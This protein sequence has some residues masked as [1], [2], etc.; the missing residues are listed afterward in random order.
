MRFLKWTLPPPWDPA[1]F[2]TLWSWWCDFTGTAAGYSGEMMQYSLIRSDYIEEGSQIRPVI[3]LK[4][5]SHRGIDE[6]CG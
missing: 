6:L 5:S 2:G 4:I 1:W 3:I